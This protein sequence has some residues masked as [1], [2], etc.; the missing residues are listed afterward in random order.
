VSAAKSARATDKSAR[1]AEKIVDFLGDLGPRWGLPAAACRVHGYLYLRAKPVGEADLVGALQMDDAALNEALEWLAD[2][3]LIERVRS[4]AWRTDSDPWELMVRV[5][6]ERQRRETGPALDLLR[7]C[8]RAALAAGPPER[9][10]AAQ[11][12]KLL[13]LAEDL[14]AINAQAQRLSPR[15]LRQVVGLGGL[16]ARF[17]DR[18]LGR[19][20]RP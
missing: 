9:T 8:R 18:T 13:R 19:R 2:Y 20:S 7:E 14:A 16:A 10:V 5:L 17:L 4:G 6:E 12:D 15:A 1:A 3:G 11:I